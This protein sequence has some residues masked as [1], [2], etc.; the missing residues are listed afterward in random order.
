MGRGHAVS[1]VRGEMDR[2]TSE[3]AS[4]SSGGGVWSVGEGTRLSEG[5]FEE[6]GWKK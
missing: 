5:F 3:V 1:R 6:F 2:C 4:K